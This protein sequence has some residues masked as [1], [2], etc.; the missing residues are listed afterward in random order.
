VDRDLKDMLKISTAVGAD[1]RLVQGGGGNT[2]VKTDGGRHMYVKASGTGLGD[3]REGLGYRLVDVARCIDI[4]NDEQLRQMEPAAR[5]M[6]VLE[7]LTACVEDDLKGRPSVETSLHAML[8]R[9]VVHTHPSVVNGLLCAVDGRQ[10]LDDLFADMDPPCLYIEYCGA[11]FPLAVRMLDAMAEYEQE[12]GRRPEIILLENHGLFVSTDDADRSLE[13]T[14][15]VFSTIEHAA[16]KRIA[17][18]TLTAQPAPADFDTREAIAQ[19]TAAARRFYAGVFGQPPLVRFTADATVRRFL[20]LASAQQLAGV[21]PMVPDQVVYCKSR[22]VWVAMPESVESLQDAVTTALTKA[23]A[24][25]QT[26]TYVIVDKLGLFC[27]APTA[28]ALDAVSATAVAVLEILTIAAQYGGARGL[29]DDAI[30]FLHN[31]EVERFRAKV[32]QGAQ[33]A[34]DLRGQVAVVTGAGSGL[35]RGISLVLAGKGVNVVLADID[36]DGAEETA[37]RMREQGCSGRGYPM[38]VD[39]TSEEA[40]ADLIQG[41]VCELGGVDLLVN[42]A[43]IAPA[44]PLTEFPVAAWRKTLEINLTGY[45]LMAREVARCMVRQQMGGNIINLSSKSGLQAS[46]HNSAYNATKAGEIH[47][48]RGWALDLAEH[49]IRVNVVC[50]G[51]VFHESKIWNPEYIETVAKKRGIKPEEVIPYYV[52]MTALKKEVTWDDIGEAVAFLASPRSAKVT[53]QVLVVDAG[54]VFVR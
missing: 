53:G 54:Q 34:E 11:G 9:C 38:R 17:E 47:L 25:A 8:G 22:P 46:K 48:A 49:G 18:A 21:N 1:T 4:V 20:K 51:N 43:G 23:E 44:Y 24:G 6:Q 5:E 19:A 15:L 42:C 35:G 10:A 31:W 26:P 50:P 16:M 30:Q 27:A 37:R 45:L 28:K 41:V 2:S 3:M 12:H 40:V 29:K 7:R 14:R 36:T 39:V 13:L 32:A 33:S 52:N